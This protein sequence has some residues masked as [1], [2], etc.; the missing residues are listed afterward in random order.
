MKFIFLK[1]KSSKLDRQLMREDLKDL[2]KMITGRS[3]YKKVN[4]LYRRR[5]KHK[6]Q[7]YQY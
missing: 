6:K 7:F 1:K 3:V 4:D 5:P 2:Q